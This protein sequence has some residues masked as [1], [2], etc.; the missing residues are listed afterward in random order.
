MHVITVMLTLP[1]IV[2][3]QQ[4]WFV[5]ITPQT[6]EIIFVRHVLLP[7]ALMMEPLQQAQDPP[8]LVLL[9]TALLDPF[10][11]PNRHKQVGCFY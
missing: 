4:I 7:M 6:L 5:Q 11:P 1:M 10:V 2:I 3:Q 8:V 9:E